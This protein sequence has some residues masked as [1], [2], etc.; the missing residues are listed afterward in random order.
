MSAGQNLVN[1]ESELGQKEKW[2]QEEE[3]ELKSDQ[4]FQNIKVIR[5][6]DLNKVFDD[7]EDESPWFLKIFF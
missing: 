4:L 6:F 3:G 2:K 5:D 7:K 1:N